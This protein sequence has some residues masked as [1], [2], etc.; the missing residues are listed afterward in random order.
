MLK[1]KSEIHTADYVFLSGV[2]SKFVEFFINLASLRE[3]YEEVKSI[4]S[5]YYTNGYKTRGIV[6]LNS[7]FYWIRL[8]DFDTKL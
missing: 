8:Q 2:V 1:Y 4:C 5:K 3:R 6:Y 7:K